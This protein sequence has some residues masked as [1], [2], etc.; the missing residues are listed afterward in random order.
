MP[1]KLSTTEI[2]CSVQKTINSIGAISMK[3]MGKVMAKAMKELSGFADG[4]LVKE[5][6]QEELSLL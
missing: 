4:K 6:V 5:I 1:N 2:R 3:D